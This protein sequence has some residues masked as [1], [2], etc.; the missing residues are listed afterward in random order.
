M[1]GSVA[2]VFRRL[3]SITL[4]WQLHLARGRRPWPRLILK[5]TPPLSLLFPSSFHPHPA[6]VLTDVVDSAG[7]ELPEELLGSERLQIVNHHGPQVEHVVAAE[8]V[9]FLE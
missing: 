9:S 4:W 8:A 5:V 3:P 7:T 6:E 2:G 1:Q